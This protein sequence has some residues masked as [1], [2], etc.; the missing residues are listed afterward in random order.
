[1]FIVV[2][3]ENYARSPWCLD[4]LAEIIRFDRTKNQVVPI[5]CY[6][7]PSDVRHHKGSFGKALDGLKKRHSAHVIVKWKSALSEIA[8]LSGHH[9]RKEA[10]E[11][12]SD[13]IRKIV[14]NVTTRAFSTTFHHEKLFGIDSAVAEIYQKLSMDS[15]DVRTIGIC[16]MGGIGKTM[17]A[18]TFYNQNVNKF[19]ISCF[20]ENFEQ[21]SQ[22]VTSLL[23]PLEQLLI[24][25][26]RKKNY[27]VIDVE[28][29]MRKLKQ[30]LHSKKAL[31]ILDDLDQTHYPKLPANL[32]NF[33]SAGSKIIITTRDVNLLNKLKVVISEIDVY[34]V[35]TLGKDDSLKL[36]SYHAFRK[37]V[38]PESFKELC[39]S[40][41]TH[42][43]GL[44]LAL[45]VLGSSLLGRTH[46]S[47]WKE[48]LA[49][50]RAIPENDI[51]KILQLSYDE[52]DDETQKAIF[53]DIAFFFVG[54][55]KDEAT[56]VFKSCDFFPGVG[57]Q[58]LLDRCLLSI[59]RHNNF[60]MHNLIQDMGRE[61]GK[62]TRLFLRGNAWKELQHLEEKF[63]VEGLVLD[64][65][66]SA[67]R[68]LST[69]IFER[70]SNLRLLQI[71]DSN[72]RVG[73]DIAGSFENLLPK[74]R[75]IRWHYC[76]WTQLPSTFRPQNLISVEMPSSKFKRLWRGPMPIKQLNYL[77]CLYL[78]GCHELKR[79][80]E[81]LGDLKALKKIDAS[82]T[83]IEKLPDSI[84]HLKE[85]VELKLSS[86]K[87]LT[88]L[89]EQL[90]E[91][92]ALKK[93][94]AGGTAIKQLPDS[95]VSLI[96]M[97]DLYL[98]WCKNLRNLP[99]DIWKLKLLKKLNLSMCSDL[100]QL[101]EQLGKMQCLE[102]LDA[103]NS[104]IEQVP[105]ST[106]QLSRL[107]EL[108]LYDCKK[109][110]Y[111]P[112]SIWNL[113]SIEDLAIHPGDTGRINLPNSVKNMKKLKALDLSCN[114]R[115]YLPIILCFS[116]LE[117]LGLIDE[118]P[119]LSSPKPFSLSEL[120]NLQ[121]L[122]LDKCTSFGSSLPE[123]PVNLEELRV[124]NHNSL[125]QLPDLSSLRKLKQLYIDGC[126]SLQSISF[127]PSH[128]QL[129]Y[130]EECTSL[131][132][133]PDM[134]VLKEL[135]E[136]CFT[137]CNNLKSISLK[138]SFLQVGEHRRPF[139]AHLPNTE[140]AEWFDYKSSGCMVSFDIPESF[141]SNFLGLALWVVYTCKA[142]KEKW[143]SIKAVIT[144]DTEGITENYPICVNIVVG[145]ARSKVHCIT[146]EK[147]SMKSGDKIKVSFSVPIGEVK[148]K[149]CGVHV[150]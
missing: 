93:L 23:P 29:K 39:R 14:E 32:S 47:F 114:V 27:K 96:N 113:T 1:M 55:D 69:V 68:E 117:R 94:D 43:G 118:G 145:E 61:L 51:Q 77:S 139:E 11:N 102:S 74:L 52:L 18:K 41:V 142:N 137:Q 59:D 36:F 127:L 13:I 115:L 136:L 49:K 122:T 67:D 120:F 141:G 71:I 107:K 2:L 111:V 150:I 133:L 35:Q 19:D 70:M 146:G 128:L 50:V 116:S 105:D 83:A 58:N 106:G 22:G 64:L 34:M 104:G 66:T 6:V 124:Y 126:I 38:P 97:E 56:D 9:L 110:R 86:C 37:P 131:Q 57:I 28:G 149:M 90:G 72:D 129:L 134:S 100:Q 112:T 140:V 21:S 48:K 147:I 121:Y 138:P 89:P 8:E 20:H 80:P 24:D 144:N 7:D 40:F 12:E 87:K 26:L 31:I 95:L 5:F 33:F 25:L 92:K 60:E 75:C 3:S 76:P 30:I 81:H 54:K 10:N 101:P 63:N 85:L 44:P 98:Y 4:E 91:I 123:L 84:T 53:L 125:E 135:E 79:L 99:K 88:R 62:S 16:G 82:F 108:H 17:I 73:S 109:L 148:V 46:E 143:T 78:S 103:N 119:I 45:K 42:A 65:T 15:N 132:D 130:V